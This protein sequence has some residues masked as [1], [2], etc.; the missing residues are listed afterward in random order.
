[1]MAFLKVLLCI[2][3]AID[4][5]VMVSETSPV[6]QTQN[7]VADKLSAEVVKKEISFD[8]DSS[9]DVKI[10]LLLSIDDMQYKVVIDITF[11]DER[12]D[13]MVELDNNIEQ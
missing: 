4:S 11:Q 6:L 2:L 13:K 7:T 1:M 9:D 3:V 10:E 5:L 12:P 8:P